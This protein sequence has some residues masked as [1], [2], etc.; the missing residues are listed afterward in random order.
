MKKIRTF[1]KLF[2]VIAAFAIVLSLASCSL[3]NGGALKLESFTVDRASVKTNYL[4]GEEIDFSGIKATAKY[5]DESLNKV[6]TFNEL[7]ITYPQDITATVGEKFVTVSFQ[8]P[9]LDVKQETKVTIKVTEELIDETP[10]PEIAVQFEKPANLT[11]FAANNNVNPDVKYGDTGF[12]GIFA[13]GGQVYVIGNANEFKL[14]P[15]FSVLNDD[16]EV[17]AKEAFF[18]VVEISLY[19]EGAYVVLTAKK[20]ENNL[21]SYYDG[22][23]LIA[24]VDTYNGSYQFSADAADKNVKIAVLPSEDRYIFE[25]FN[26]V[27][28][29]AKIID[30]YNVYEAWQLAVIDNDPSDDRGYKLDDADI[31]DT[32]KAEKGLANVNVAGI[33]IHNDITVTYEDVPAEFFRA[34]TKDTEYTNSTT[35]EK[36]TIPAGTKYLKDW[37][38]IYRRVLNPGET[39]VV[40]GNL[41]TIDLSSFPIIASPAVFDEEG[42]DDD[43]GTDFSNATFIKF[44]TLDDTEIENRNNATMSNIHIIGNASRNNMVD[45]DGYL[46]SAG[47]LILFKTYNQVS[48]TCNNLIGNSCFITYFT[49]QGSKIVANNIKCY[50]SYQNAIYAYGM[51]EMEFYDSFFNGAGGPSVI[52]SSAKSDASTNVYTTP[53]FTSTNTVFETHLTGEEIWFTAVNATSVVSQI[54]GLGK[55]LAQAGLGNFVDSTGNMNIKGLLMAEG[56]NA[57]AILMGV[58]AAG[59]ISLNGNGISRLPDDLT[60]QTINYL[61]SVNPATMSAPFLTVQDAQGN[62][63][64]IFYAGEQV[65]FCDLTGAV[66]NPAGSLEHAAIYQALIS[67]DTITLTMGGISVVFDFYH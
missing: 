57:D 52:L 46:V 11:A 43:Y 18:S 20:G 39:F 55:G 26:A 5:S 19:K 21:V 13:K 6:Y 48:L 38:E 33:V 9:H 3:F 64:T 15:A 34:T 41:F 37:S 4:V 65:G 44:V 27:V 24:T 67:A 60:W 7:T 28:L 63:H 22:E 45:A 2:A 62:S 42:N 35:G 36:E 59:S 56:D 32:F 61:Y 66:F 49:E 40:E 51:S 17:E 10:D 50:D 54:K 23:T 29:E 30:A 12:S 1:S 16:G 58:T 53:K 31:W 8:D 14:N 25:G 47:G